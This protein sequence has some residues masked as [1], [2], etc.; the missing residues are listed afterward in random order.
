MSKVIDSLR[1][2]PV[3]SNG[4]LVTYKVSYTLGNTFT[5]RMGELD[6]YPG[7]ISEGIDVVRRMVAEEVF[8]EYKKDLQEVQRRTMLS[9]DRLSAALISSILDSMFE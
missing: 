5:I 6:S 2:V 9:G 7:A 3:L 1:A 8:G 4:A